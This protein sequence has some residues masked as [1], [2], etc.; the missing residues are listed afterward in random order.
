MPSLQK[1]S[2]SAALSAALIL[3]P[4]PASAL[5]VIVSDPPSLNWDLV[6]NALSDGRLDAGDLVGVGFDALWSATGDA[7]AQT[8]ICREAYAR[9]YSNRNSAAFTFDITVTHQGDPPV[10]YAQPVRVVPHGNTLVVGI[11]KG[12]GGYAKIFR[13]GGDGAAQP[14]QEDPSAIALLAHD[15][16]APDEVVEATRESRGGAD[17]RMFDTDH[18]RILVYLPDDISV[19]DRIS[20]TVLAEPAGEDETQRRANADRLRGYA[21]DI[22]GARTSVAD[23]LIRFAAASTAVVSLL[24]RGGRTVGQTTIP[25]IDPLVSM[26]AGM[27]TYAAPTQGPEPGVRYL[28]GIQFGIPTI[29]QAGRP[30][31][32]SG[33]FDGDATTTSCTVNRAPCPI[34]AESP[35]QTVFMAPEAPTGPVNIQVREGANSAQGVANNIGISLSAQRLVLARGEGTDVTMQVDGADGIRAPIQVRLWASSSVR[36]QGGNQQTVI[37]DPAAIDMSGAFRQGFVLRALAPGPFDIVA[38]LAGPVCAASV[39]TPAQNAYRQ[40]LLNVESALQRAEDAMRALTAARE[41][42]RKAMSDLGSASMDSL[43]ARYASLDPNDITGPIRAAVG[44]ARALEAQEQTRRRADGARTAME[45]AERRLRD[46]EREVEGASQARRDSMDGI[47]AA[48]REA[49]DAQERARAQQRRCATI[50]RP[51]RE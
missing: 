24:D 21:V 44:L 5:N 15:W 16:L 10:S 35:R 34:L 3:Q 37:V 49:I 36:L 18:G 38:E 46:A 47:S 39:D 43:N 6:I 27:S 26:F 19:G 29:T 51:I 9:S 4:A 25:I 13:C 33:V 17:I 40:A 14:Q 12:D 8:Q 1:F 48:E 45:E 22:G 41:A 32:I 2:I 11:A 50:S 20:G 23:R 7:I 31:V 28:Y 42:Y 30:A